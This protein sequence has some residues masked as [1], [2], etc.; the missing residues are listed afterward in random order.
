MSCALFLPV[1]RDYIQS[2]IC[3]ITNK[4]A[5]LVR[6]RIKALGIGNTVR[7]IPPCLE[8]DFLVVFSFVDIL[9]PECGYYACTRYHLVIR[10]KAAFVEVLVS[11]DAP[12]TSIDHELK[13]LKGEGHYY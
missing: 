3:L 7:V 8:G 6:E 9:P 12:V 2:D 11:N 4:N 10:G 5:D 13:H 1:K